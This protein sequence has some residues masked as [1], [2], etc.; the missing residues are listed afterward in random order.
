MN[1]YVKKRILK[2]LG[3]VMRKNGLENL[4]RRGTINKNGSGKQRVIYLS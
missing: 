4:I 1:D 3:N 2:F